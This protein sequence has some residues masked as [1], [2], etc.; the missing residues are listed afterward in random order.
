MIS[1]VNVAQTIH[2]PKVGRWKNVIRCFVYDTI[3]HLFI[4]II[5]IIGVTRQHN[6]DSFA[7]SLFLVHLFSPAFLTVRV[8]CSPAPT[9]FEII[10]AE[11]WN[12]FCPPPPFPSALRH[13]ECSCCPYCRYC[14]FV[15]HRSYLEAACFLKADDQY[16]TICIL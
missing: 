6:I 10:Q 15:R 4:L 2:F 9:T 16:A 7:R 8:S 3:Y 12:R 14:V 11:C 13:L 1:N 5:F